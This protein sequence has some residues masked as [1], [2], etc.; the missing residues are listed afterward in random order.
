MM[1]RKA[2][3]R[4]RL[5]SNRGTIPPFAWRYW[6]K[7]RKASQQVFLPS[8]SG[9]TY[10]TRT[11]RVTVT[12]TCSVSVLCPCN[13]RGTGMA[14]GCISL[15]IF[16]INRGHIVE[17]VLLLVPLYSESIPMKSPCCNLL[18]DWWNSDR[19]YGLVVRVS[20]Y[21]PR[22]PWFD[23]RPYQ[24]FWEVRGLERG[25]LNLLRIVEELLERKC[26]GSGLEKR[27]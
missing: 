13:G 4:K 12:T 8:F 25:P 26:S 6:G 1:R 18:T 23:S 11:K 22:G 7:P 24:I 5:W 14:T 15:G 2:F 3:G 9:S 20:G 21:R 19:L 27:D 16:L 10:R 17:F